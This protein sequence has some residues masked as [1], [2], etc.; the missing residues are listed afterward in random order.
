MILTEKHLCSKPYHIDEISNEILTIPA[1][2][3]V[4]ETTFV[5]YGA[6]M[7]LHQRMKRKKQGFIVQRQQDDVDGFYVPEV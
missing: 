5:K 2:P 7:S 6:D 3:R 1:D 4:R